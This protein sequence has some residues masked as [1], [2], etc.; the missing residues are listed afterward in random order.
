M[1]ETLSPE[2][3]QELYRFLIFIAIVVMIVWA[4]FA[5]TIR[6]T[7]NLIKEENR[8]LLP[9]Q[10]WFLVVPLF[11]IYWNFE[12]ARRLSFSLNNEFYD[13]KIEVEENPG[14]RAGMIYSF[15]FLAYYIPFPDFFKILTFIV[16]VVYF[17]S[18]WYKINS[19]RELIIEHNKWL[20]S[21]DQKQDKHE[22]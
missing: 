9:Y 21:Q 20:E 4:L 3:V 8:F 14:Y 18:Y 16:C 15:A 10:A 13:R 5:N 11:N 12:V 6:L 2:F 17:I 1:P 19:Y 22:N 7:L